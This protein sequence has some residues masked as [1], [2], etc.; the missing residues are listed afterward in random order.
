MLRAGLVNLDFLGLWRAGIEQVERQDGG[1][2]RDCSCLEESEKI[3]RGKQ[4]NNDSGPD[5]QEFTFIGS[6]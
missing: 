1:R 2:A 3:V 5:F 6:K 4:N